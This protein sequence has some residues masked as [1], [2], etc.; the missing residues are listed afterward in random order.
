M[1]NVLKI[2]S[3]VYAVEALWKSINWVKLNIQKW[4]DQHFDTD[5]AWVQYQAIECTFCYN[6][7]LTEG[8]KMMWAQN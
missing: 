8:G 4:N 3:S 6:R 7:N 1:S 2:Y 5:T